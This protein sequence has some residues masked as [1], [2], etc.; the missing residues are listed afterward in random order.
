M[1]VD[2]M[3]L[4]RLLRR[5]G[6]SEFAEEA[7]SSQPVQT[8]GVLAL[9]RRTVERGRDCHVLRDVWDTE[10]V[11]SSLESARSRYCSADATLWVGR[12]N[13]GD[14]RRSAARALRS[15]LEQDREPSR[16]GGQP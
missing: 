5:F 8:A 6:F 9:T 12:F 10:D 14:Y 4:L 3:T 2:T 15:V 13:N 11:A 16:S 7:V 1:N